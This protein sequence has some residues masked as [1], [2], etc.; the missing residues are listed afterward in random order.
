MGGVGYIAGQAE[1]GG[2]AGQVFVEAGE[3]GDA[4]VESLGRFALFPHGIAPVLH[5]GHRRAQQLF[6]P[7]G[8]ANAH[9]LGETQHVAPV[10]APGVR[11]AVPG[12]PALEHFCNASVEAF[13]TG[14]K[15]P[16]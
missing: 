15:A 13:G 14:P 8:P 7:F 11:A 9:E 2:G 5:V 3:R 10:S 1:L 16:E 6:S 4:A 12:G